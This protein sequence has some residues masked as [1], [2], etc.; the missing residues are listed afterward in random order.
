MG[1]RVLRCYLTVARKENNTQPALMTGKNK[2]CVI[3][4]GFG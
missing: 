2:P 4:K 1:L 3:Q